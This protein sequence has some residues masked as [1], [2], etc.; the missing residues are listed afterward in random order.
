MYLN[1]WSRCY[2]KQDEN[3]W[4]PV[5]TAYRT[6]SLCH[7]EARVTGTDRVISLVWIFCYCASAWWTHPPC[8]CRREMT[9]S[10]IRSRI[11]TKCTATFQFTYM[12]APESSHLLWNS[13]CKLLSLSLSFRPSCFLQHLFSIETLNLCNLPF[14][15]LVYSSRKGLKTISMQLLSA[16]MMAARLQKE[17]LLFPPKMWLDKKNN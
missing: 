10:H 9:I 5:R 2:H 8:L 3:C 15:L 17:K 4:S 6:R 11:Q 13:S 1:E 7:F 12:T 16:L 14:W